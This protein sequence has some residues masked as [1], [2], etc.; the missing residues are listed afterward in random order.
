MNVV[1]GGE[2]APERFQGTCFVAQPIFAFMSRWVIQNVSKTKNTDKLLIFRLV[3]ENRS[4]TC[5][6][7]VIAVPRQLD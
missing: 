2:I 1:F 5:A 3:Q 6:Q 4:D 7:N